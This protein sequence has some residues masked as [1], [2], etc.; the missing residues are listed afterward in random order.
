MH[1]AGHGI[2]HTYGPGVVL[3]D[4]M[5]LNLHEIASMR[6]VPELV[7]I[8]C[9]HLGRLDGG[10]RDPL[11]GW[12]V[13]FAARV[14][15]QLMRIGVRCVVA[16]GWAVDD[17]PARDFALTFY[18]ALL[19]GRPFID[20][21]AQAR[22]ATWAS[23][24]DSITWAAYQC[25]GD[26]NWAYTRAA[27]DDGVPHIA[28]RRVEPIVSTPALALAIKTPPLLAATWDLWRQLGAEAG[29][30][31]ELA[32]GIG[33]WRL[34][35]S[36]WTWWQHPAEQGQG[37]RDL[38]R[39]AAPSDHAQDVDTG[40][41]PPWALSTWQPVADALRWLGGGNSPFQQALRRRI[42]DAV[43]EGEWPARGVFELAD[44][45]MLPHRYAATAYSELYQ[46]ALARADRT[47]LSKLGAVGEG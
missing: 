12:R 19:A 27:L 20:A 21:V 39:L 37:C 18:D 4:G 44:Q 22:Q 41:Q 46:S 45:F 6:T 34:G 35:G 13:A 14:A 7:F 47:H 5:V 29:L 10:K 32:V 25:Y 38:L 15:E 23:Y 42:V 33:Q 28:G 26:P 31:P 2:E 9:C 11:Q 1:I 36:A 24:P 43:A 16:A 30:A 3:S 40:L 17:L 8:N